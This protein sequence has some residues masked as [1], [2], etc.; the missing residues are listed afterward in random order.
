MA[1]SFMI[2]I[3]REGV[4]PAAYELA[5][6][7]SVSRYVSGGHG[8]IVPCFGLDPINGHRNRKDIRGWDEGVIDQTVIDIS[9]G[10]VARQGCWLGSPDG[11]GVVGRA[12]RL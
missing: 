4:A 2:D 3:H 6:S 12:L 5:H 8:K 1:C 9:R 7:W 10:L 11:G